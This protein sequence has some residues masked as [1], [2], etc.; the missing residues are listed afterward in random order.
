ME[1][2]MKVSLIITI[3]NEAD[4]SSLLE[5]IS[6]QTIGPDEFV[7]TDAG[8]NSEMQ[9]VG[10]LTKYKNKKTVRFI[11]LPADANRSV[12]RNKAI[13]AA[14]HEHI[15]I[16]DA[17]CTLEEHWVERM[18][19][20]FEKADVVAGY[21]AADCKNTFEKCVAPYALVMPDKL[22]VK[23][24]LPATRSMGI[25][26][27]VWQEIGKFDED[28][29]YAEDYALARK[30]HDSRIKIHVVADAVVYWRPRGNLSSFARMIY[31]HA[32]GDAYNKIFRPK[33]AFIFVRYFF[34]IGL[35]LLSLYFWP[36]WFFT[37]QLSIVYIVYSIVKNYRYVRD[38]RAVFILPVL[39]ILS[40]LCVMTA[41]AVGLLQ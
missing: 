29:R 16:T 37:L 6:K 18:K 17:G 5:S 15:L 20:G 21:Y 33:V 9:S 35:M 41:T 34:F 4:I 31:E 28:F 14:K 39:Q 26:K 36:L 7:F 13:T 30:I 38:G 10:W 40:D 3:K 22:N 12:G 24:F 32:Y 25:T 27:K 2:K 8:G 11:D 23:T 1:T 19:E